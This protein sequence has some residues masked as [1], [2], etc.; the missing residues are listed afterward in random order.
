MLKNFKILL[1]VV[2]LTSSL[3]SCSTLS[4][5]YSSEGLVGSSI[6]ALGGAGIG[7]AVGTQIG[8]KTEN[9]LLAAG[10]GAGLGALIGGSMHAD[11]KEEQAKLVV[12]RK[13]REKDELQA[14]I[15]NLREDYNDSVSWGR[16][17]TKSWNERYEGDDFSSPYEGTRR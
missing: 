11:A 9:T 15:D 6:G 2:L 7:Y 1:S 16:S 4:G 3:S 13:A 5:I 14:K 12:V 10:I 17:E 8:K